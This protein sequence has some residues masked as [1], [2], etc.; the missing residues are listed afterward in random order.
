MQKYE[1]HYENCPSK[2]CASFKAVKA[3]MTL[4]AGG[5]ETWPIPIAANPGAKIVSHEG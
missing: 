2:T 3:E 1:K 4:S 5:K